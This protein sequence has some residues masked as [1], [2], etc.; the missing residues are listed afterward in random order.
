MNEPT[1]HVLALTW[2]IRQ[3]SQNERRKR[4]TG[5]ETDR[6]RYLNHQYANI[7]S[8][9]L[10]T[11]EMLYI[12]ICSHKLSISFHKNDLAEGY[13]EKNVNALFLKLVDFENSFLVCNFAHRLAC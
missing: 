11:K 3:I 4:N 1:R 7:Y 10:L 8:Q 12:N 9:C 2:E 6:F 13:F 5:K